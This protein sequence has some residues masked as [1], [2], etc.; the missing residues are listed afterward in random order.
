MKKFLVLFISLCVLASV[1]TGC[2]TTPEPTEPPPTQTPVIIILTPTLAAEQ[3]T[4]AEPVESAEVPSSPEPTKAPP[5]P[6]ERATA[7]PEATNGA[8]VEPTETT[9]AATEEPTEAPPPPTNTPAVG[10]LKYP[11]PVLLE[12][13][14]NQ[15][16]GWKS[17]VLMIWNSVGELAED[18]YYHLHMERR[19]QTEGQEW[20]GDYVYTK[21]TEY[22][23]EGAFLDPFHPPQAQGQGVVYWWVRVVRKTGEDANGKPIG[24]DISPYS[25]QRTLILNPKP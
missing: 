18:E 3:P 20:Y 13:P 5:T 12:P 14:A 22:R 25:E 17:T 8:T 1:V 21:D 9:E 7:E 24:I 19:P 16:V 11:P 2:G 23:A 15:P 10:E 4:A 6:T